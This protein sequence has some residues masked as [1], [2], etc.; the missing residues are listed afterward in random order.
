MILDC[1]THI[2][3]NS[4]I[5]ATAVDL[6]KS[7]NDADIDKALVFAGHINDC[8][9]EWMAEQIKRF[10]DRLYGIASVHMK[11]MFTSKDMSLDSL[12]R[13]LDNGAVG[14]KLY[15]GYEHF[16]PNSDQV[17]FVLDMIKPYKRPVIFHTGDCLNSIS[18]AK[19]KYAMP[20]DIDDI[21]VDFPDQTF[22]I[23][24][25][26]FP[27]VREAAQVCYKNKNV[28]ADTSGFVY[29]QFSQDDI[30]QF[31]IALKEFTNRDVD[32]KLLFGT[33]FPI[34]NQRSYIDVFKFDLCWQL[35]LLSD[36]SNKLFSLK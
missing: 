30:N 6:I 31:E 11:E 21:A 17:R 1:H 35:N 19:L 18:N 8:S 25:M 16:A 9:N 36:L 22:V 2:G 32:N 20:L 4:H 12:Y 28:Y 29:G 26:G 34:S 3:R 33:D 14:V 24:H 15:T 7:M 27:F 10:K 5:N 23:A 13:A